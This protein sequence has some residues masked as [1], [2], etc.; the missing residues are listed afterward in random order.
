VVNAEPEKSPSSPRNS[1]RKKPP[2][3]PPIESAFANKEA[4]IA[5]VHKIV[6]S[7]KSSIRIVNQ[8]TQTEAQPFDSKP[9]LEML[10]QHQSRLILLEQ[11]KRNN[12]LDLK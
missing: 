3:N 6:A 11:A 4:M 10:K 8:T 9:H 5:E 7:I 12:R 1:K 2:T